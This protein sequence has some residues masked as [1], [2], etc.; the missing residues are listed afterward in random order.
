MH[1]ALF[2]AIIDS[3]NAHKSVVQVTPVCCCGVE[4]LEATMQ[5]DIQRHNGTQ[6]LAQ[7]GEGGVGSEADAEAAALQDQ[8]QL[9]TNSPDLGLGTKRDC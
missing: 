3:S 6:R 4:G 9:T 1:P 2:A 7:R 8:P 5:A